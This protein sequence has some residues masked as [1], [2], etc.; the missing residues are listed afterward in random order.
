MGVNPPGPPGPNGAPNSP[1]DASGT[2]YAPPQGSDQAAEG[3]TTANLAYQRA[4][5]RF[6]QQRTG[7]LQQYG[8][9]GTV[10]P[11]TG[12]MTNVGVDAG[13]SYG[14][15]QQ[16][17]HTQANEDQQAAYAAENRGLVGGLAN[18][19]EQEL[20][21]GHHGQSSALANSLFGSLSDLNSQQL[22]AKDTLDQALWQLQ[23]DATTGAVS[24]GGYSPS[25]TAPGTSGSTPNYHAATPKG[26]PAQI[27]AA[28]AAAMR[29]AGGKSTP[30]AALAARSAG[31]NAAY[32]L[33]TKA[34]AKAAP[35]PVANAYT[36]PKS[37]K[38]G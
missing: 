36:N 9:K 34:A 22:D 4:L 35:K 2:Y 11:T 19:G 7:L 10:D 8:Y 23:H 29:A 21:Y 3:Y 24:T 14:Q 32:G 16:L 30:A 15:L 13:N 38:R 5:A 20:S 17:L 37:K 25:G 26:T 33:A 1:A 27:A 18:Q 6:N 31:M 12:L 28:A